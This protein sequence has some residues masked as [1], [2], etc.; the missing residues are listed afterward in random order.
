MDINFFFA[1]ADAFRRLAEAHD[2]SLAEREHLTS[3]VEWARRLVEQLAAQD[4][5]SCT[6]A[7][8]EAGRVVGEMHHRAK[9]AD[10][11]IDLIHE[12]AAE[13]LSH[14]QIAQKFDAEPKVSRATVGRVLRGQQRAQTVMGHRLVTRTA[15]PICWPASPDEFDL[16]VH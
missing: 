2:A 9:L 11:D 10:A 8:N 12:L 7:V 14:A 4:E 6:A 1:A 3:Y 15:E 16:V 13:G 5:V